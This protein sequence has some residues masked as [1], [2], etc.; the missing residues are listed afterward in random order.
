MPDAA[1]H[2]GPADRV[3]VSLPLHFTGVGIHTNSSKAFWRDY[4]RYRHQQTI[5]GSFLELSMH[6]Y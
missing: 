2:P 4:K 5:H 6:I 1:S 3:T